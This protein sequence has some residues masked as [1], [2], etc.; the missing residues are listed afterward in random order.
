MN[1]PSERLPERFSSEMS[2]PTHYGKPSNSHK[3][4]A[5][6]FERT[7]RFSFPALLHL[8]QVEKA[9]A[10]AGAFFIPKPNRK[11][12]LPANILP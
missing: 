5:I 8:K 4:K 6:F 2:S 7:W 1:F 11:K 12:T 9:P 10:N 3:T